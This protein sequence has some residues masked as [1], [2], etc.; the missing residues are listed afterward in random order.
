[1]YVMDIK[2]IRGICRDCGQRDQTTMISDIISLPIIA[3]YKNI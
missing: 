1:M 2:D 3:N